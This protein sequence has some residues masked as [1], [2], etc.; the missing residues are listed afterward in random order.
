[1]SVSNPITSTDS[2]RKLFDLQS[3]LQKSCTNSSA[4]QTAVNKKKERKKRRP[5]KSGESKTL[6]CKHEDPVP[7]KFQKTDIEKVF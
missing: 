4:T 2:L 6:G 7:G 1:M 5:L 3:L